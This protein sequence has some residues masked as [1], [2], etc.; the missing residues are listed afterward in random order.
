VAT[1]ATPRVYIKFSKSIATASI[2]AA[3]VRWLT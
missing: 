1:T 2:E 3:S